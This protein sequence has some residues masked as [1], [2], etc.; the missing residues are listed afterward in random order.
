MKKIIA[1][2]I[3]SLLA[4][5]AAT[6]QEPQKKDAPKVEQQ[7]RHGHGGK[8]CGNCPNHGKHHGGHGHAHGQQAQPQAPQYNADGIDM[9]VVRAFPTVKSVKKTAKLTEVYDANSKL[10]GYALYS[11]PASDGIK[12][13]AGETPVLIAL[14]TKKIILGVWLLGNVETPRYLQRVEEAGF[15]KNWNGLS[16][17]KALKKEV[18]AVS[19]ATFTS[20]AVA[21][22]VRAALEQL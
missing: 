10:L 5:G 15:Y 9:A 20:K 13:Y 1:L 3:V 11:K 17:K 18:D 7:A 4:V 16:V 12:G 8:H 21:A 19:G 22:S 2:T 6:A 14:S